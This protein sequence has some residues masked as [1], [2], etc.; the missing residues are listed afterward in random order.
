VSSM[1][2]RKMSSPGL[3][4]TRVRRE[5]TKMDSWQG[6]KALCVSNWSE[7]EYVRRNARGSGARRK[8]AMAAGLSVALGENGAEGVEEWEQGS[9]LG[10]G[11]GPRLAMERRRGLCAC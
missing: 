11:M 3:E 6:V 1:A 10:E 5:T 8:L 2:R 9:A 4:K 7:E